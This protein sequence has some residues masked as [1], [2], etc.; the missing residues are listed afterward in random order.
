[1]ITSNRIKFFAVST[2]IIFLTLVAGKVYSQ[3]VGVSGNG[4]D[5]NNSMNINQ[6]DSGTVNQSSSADVN[7]D[8]NAISDTGGNSANDNVG[9]VGITTGDASTKVD[10]KNEFN[11]NIGDVD[12]KDKICPTPTPK[13]SP[14][15]TKQVGGPISTPTPSGNGG[16]GG[17]DGGDGGRGGEAGAAQ[18]PAVL[19][20]A[21][22]SGEKSIL[23][24][25]PGFL[26]ILFGL[27]LIK[28]RAKA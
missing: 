8:V 13:S 23:Q 19:G 7:N 6:K 28:K 18:A 21:A 24:I 17:G 10:I 4:P 3:S 15:P 16:N 14:T 26:S 5:S 20:L 9:G 1:M 12:C 25:L 2:F 11:N 22:A 27:G